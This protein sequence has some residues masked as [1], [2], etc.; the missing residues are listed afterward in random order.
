MLIKKD[1]KKMSYVGS[2]A[3]KGASASGLGQIRRFISN[4]D[5]IFQHK[6]IQCKHYGEK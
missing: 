4:H 3:V 1:M 2:L 6:N 5:S